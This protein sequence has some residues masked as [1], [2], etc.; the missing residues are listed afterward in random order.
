M[1]GYKQLSHT[2]EEI[3]ETIRS[4]QTHVNDTSAHTNDAE[5]ASWNAKANAADVY[6]I[7]AANAAFLGRTETAAAAV[8][9]GA[10][11]N[12]AEQFAGIKTDK[13][14]WR[15]GYAYDSSGA[16]GWHKIA[17]CVHRSAFSAL[18]SVTFLIV[19]SSAAMGILNVRLLCASGSTVALSN[20]R[21]QWLCRSSN[22][23]SED[24]IVTAS[25]ENGSVS[26]GLWARIA[27]SQASCK[28]VI[29]ENSN[30]SVQSD[31]GD[32][33]QTLISSV[34][35]ETYTTS[36]FMIVPSDTLIAKYDSNGNDIAIKLAELESRLAALESAAATTAE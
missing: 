6:T 15:W 13:T 29:L 5:R 33:W 14:P 21:A 11:G 30:R 16:T 7:A 36:D 35:S 12:I 27:A 22:L 1:A 25:V 2:A 31:E 18:R 10:G 3:D 8:L 24:F 23:A 9:D 26:A 34:P 28:V 17:S 32:Y 19:Q 20:A 4:E